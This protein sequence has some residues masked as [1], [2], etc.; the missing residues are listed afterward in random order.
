MSSS[1]ELSRRMSVA[2]DR[3]HEAL[4]DALDQL[5]GELVS[6]LLAHKDVPG[7]DLT[8]GKA[9]EHLV[10][11]LGCAHRIRPCPLEQIEELAVFTV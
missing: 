1:A 4:V 11:Q 5:V 10:E 7:E 2:I 3:R 8:L 6:V 9:R